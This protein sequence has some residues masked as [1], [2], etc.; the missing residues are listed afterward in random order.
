MADSTTVTGVSGRYATALFEI[1]REGERLEQTGSE[2]KAIDDAL[3]ESADLRSLVSSPLY[4]RDQQAGAIGAL[5]DRMNIAGAVRNAVLLMAQKGRLYMLAPVIRDFFALQRAA[6]GVVEAEVR[7]ARALTDAQRDTLK[8]HLK[9]AAGGEI[10]LKETVDESLLGGVVVRL[11]SKM[12]DAS[13]RNRLNQL[14]TAMKEA[15]L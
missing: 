8:D 14:Q 11:G 10:I 4:S 12:I 6:D 3:T 5:L 9:S 2:L 7:S 13:L 15:T 1:A